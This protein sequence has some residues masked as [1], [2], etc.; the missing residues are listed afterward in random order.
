[1]GHRMLPIAFFPTDPRSHGNEI[2]DKM[3]YNS[4][5]VKDFCEI[6]ALVG[7]FRKS[8]IECCQLQFSPPTPVA[9]AAKFETK[10]ASFY[11]Y[12]KV[13]GNGPSNAVICIVLDQLPLPS[14]FSPIDPRCLGNEI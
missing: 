14:H 12:K 11:A 13:F 6:L 8:A 9:M 5:W 1:M 2:W 4:V 7:V 3:D 10:C